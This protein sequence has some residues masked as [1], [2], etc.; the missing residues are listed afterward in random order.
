MAVTLGSNGVLEANLIIP[1]STTFA[2][3]I[4]HTDSEG[5]P[6]DH[7]GYIPHMRIIDKKKTQHDVGQYVTFDDSDVLIELPSTITESLALGSGKYD[8]MLEDPSGHVVRLLYGAVSIID[9]YSLDD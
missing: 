6:I 1:Q 8:L 3:A 5:T 7:T 9:T 4:E 2:C